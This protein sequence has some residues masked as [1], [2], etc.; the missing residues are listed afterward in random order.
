MRITR[1]TV[2]QKNYKL[3]SKILSKSWLKK[4]M[5]TFS[6]EEKASDCYLDLSDERIGQIVQALAR[7]VMEGSISYSMDAFMI[8]VNILNKLTMNQI[9][10]KLSLPASESSMGM[11][12][13]DFSICRTSATS[14]ECDS[15][16]QAT[17]RTVTE[18]AEEGETVHVPVIRSYIN[19]A[20]YHSLGASTRLL[21]MQLNDAF[22]M[23]S[24]Q[25]IAMLL[26]A[27]EDSLLVNSASLSISSKGMSSRGIDIGCW[28]MEL[29]R[30]VKPV[31]V[32]PK[33]SMCM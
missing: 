31:F 12:L 22:G 19:D 8:C 4:L 26:L 33:S 5:D 30:T 17:D 2:K 21:A 10:L 6:T 24:M 25:I 29:K 28:E 14:P 1:R 20:D 27:A 18:H 7:T 11:D 9:N 13:L 15:L 32:L 16:T 23:Q 3:D